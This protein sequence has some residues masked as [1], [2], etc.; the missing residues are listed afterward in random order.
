VKVRPR[1]PKAIFIVDPESLNLIYGPEDRRKLEELAEFY[2]PEQTRESIMAKPDVLAE[3]EVIFSG[4]GAPMMDENFLKAA[5]ELRAV[6]YGAGTIGYC[7]SDA[8]WDRGI[9]ITSAY[10]ANA[11]PVAEYTVATI[12]LSLKKF[13]QFVARAKKGD[14]WAGEHRRY[15]PGCFETTVALV[16]CGTVARGVIALLKSVDIRCIV[17]DPFLEK[18]EA[19]ALGVKLCTLEEAFREGDVVSLHTADKPE[20]RGMIRGEHFSAMKEGATFINT[21]R[22]RI[23]RYEEM[24]EVLRRR[25]DIMAILDVL[26]QEPPAVQ[27]PLLSMENVIVSPHIAGSLGPECRRLGRYMV[28]EFQRYLADEPLKWQ[29]TKELSAKLA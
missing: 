24:T 18:S 12:L 13:W 10:A 20:T 21:A 16:G 5:P 11:Q 25:S 14:G 7:T 1:R 22:S 28:E 3:A 15:V 29:I 27:L 6:F 8:F 4:W 9:L 17:C 19:A 2:A 23:V 26:D